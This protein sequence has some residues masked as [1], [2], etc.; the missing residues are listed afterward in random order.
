MMRFNP[1]TLCT[2]V[3]LITLGTNFL[4]QSSSNA[5]DPPSTGVPGRRSDAGSRSCGE[6]ESSRLSGSKPLTA[7]VPIEKT[8]SSTVV[9]GKTAAAYPTFW[10]YL[11]H[12]S[13]AT[14]TFVLQDQDGDSVYQSDVALPKTA[15][16]ISLTLPSTVPPL[17]TGQRYQWFFKLYCRS[18]SPPDSF[19]NGWI[20]RE[21]IA[22]KLTPQLKTATPQQQ[23]QLYATHGF[24]YEALSTAVELR[25]QNTGEAT[26]REL[27]RSIGLEEIA[28]EPIATP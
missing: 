24:W 7:L 23:V 16:I 4:G 6:G 8:A 26:W 22:P 11:P 25:H 14:A 9:L 21:S 19:V 3:L 12:R 10:F 13:A 27:L 20:Q 17:V 5:T 28:T 1:T 15:G 2:I 18:T